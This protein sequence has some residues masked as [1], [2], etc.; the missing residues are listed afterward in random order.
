M[1]Y[2]QCAVYLLAARF[3]AGDLCAVEPLF[4]EVAPHAAETSLASF[5]FAS[6]A[7]TS[8]TVPLVGCKCDPVPH[9]RS[10]VVNVEPS[11]CCRCCGTPQNENW[12]SALLVPGDRCF[13]DFVSPMTNPVYFED[14]R[15]LTEAR[16]IYLHHQIPS[17]AQGGAA[18]VF[19]LQLRAALTDRLS[20]IATK[21]GFVTSTNPL[22]DDGWCDV[23]LGLKY[24]LYAD[25]S[26]QRLLSA[27]MTFEIPAGSTRALQG[28]GDGMFDLF[29][30]GGTQFGGC[31]HWISASGFL[32]PT[33]QS[34]ESSIWFWS[35][36]VDHRLAHTN[37]Y[38]FGETNW[39]HYMSAGKAFDA[40]PIE[41]G[42]LFN[43]G[44]VGVAGNDIVTG[45]LGVKYKPHSQMELGFAWETPLTDRRDVIEN[46]VNVDCI[47]RY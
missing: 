20:I 4:D 25:P 16:F 46:R 31:N 18:N 1:R 47:L 44:A 45:A 5:Q 38:F 42:D 2:F 28:N 34:A 13:T 3:M 33:D 30:T 14:P 6:F 35:N 15:T 36:H 37:F 40:A 23:A 10:N 8:E 32:L 19:A 22:I 21:D 11:R 27:G 26:R 43:L 7:G 17:A 39:Y 9:I 29:L 41:G 12:L 24:N